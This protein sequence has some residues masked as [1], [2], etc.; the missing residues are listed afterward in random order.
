MNK[1][2]ISTLYRRSCRKNNSYVLGV[3]NDLHIAI[4]KTIQ[5]ENNRGG[6]YI[7]EIIEVEM[8]DVLELTEKYHIIVHGEKHLVTSKFEFLK[9]VKL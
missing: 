5:E 7:G 8:G 2:Y 3:F 4:R 6:K 1:Y 9:G